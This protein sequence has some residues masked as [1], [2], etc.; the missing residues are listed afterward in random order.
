[1]KSSIETSLELKVLTLASTF[2]FILF[3]F[4]VVAGIF[5][6]CI[7]ISQINLKK[8]FIHGDLSHHDIS[9]FRRN[10]IPNIRGNF[11]TI[12]LENMQ[13]DFESLPWI[14]S[15]TVKRVFPNQ[16]DIHIQEHK[17][18]A[19]WGARDDFKMINAAGVLFDSSMDDEY[20]NLPQLIGPEGQNGL[21]LAVYSKLNTILKPLK[22][23][24]V[25]IEL[26]MRGSWVATLEGGAR[27]ELGRG[28][29]DTLAERIKNF[30]D[31]VE[32]VTSGFN[33]NITT[34]QYADIRHSNGYALKING[35]TTM[36]HGMFNQTAKK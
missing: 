36:D 8:I 21:M 15:A 27:L 26:S 24:L 31:T 4:L 7:S 14:H 5:I 35:I 10:I 32:I 23:K 2:L 29:I 17:P 16:I 6:S 18:I 1:M 19:I 22:V 28:S 34:L 30:T 33:K 25:K 11:F 9:S 12:N 3:G 20:D 13:Q